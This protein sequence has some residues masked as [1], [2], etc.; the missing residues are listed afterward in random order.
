V[1]EIQGEIASIR[2]VEYD[3]D[4]LLRGLEKLP[5]FFVLTAHQFRKIVPLL[6]AEGNGQFRYSY[7][8]PA[9]EPAP[10]YLEALS[11]QIQELLRDEIVSKAWAKSRAASRC[12]NPGQRECPLQKGLSRKGL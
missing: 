1:S 4:L 6:E 12:R 7:L 3:E 5:C 10:L 8:G 9:P 2:R 11:K